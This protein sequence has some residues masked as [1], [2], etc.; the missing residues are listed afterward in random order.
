MSTVAAISTGMSPGGIGIVRISGENAVEI[1]EKVF[2]SKNGKLLKDLRG[3]SALLGSV[4]GED[5]SFLDEVIALVFKAPRSYTGEDVVELSCHGGLFVTRQVLRSVL[6]AGALPAPAGEFTKRAFLNGKMD[7]ASA[8]S[9]MNIISSHSE[10][11]AKAAYNTLEG[12]LSKKLAEINSVLVSA[13]ASL[14]AWVDYPD[15]EIE[16]LTSGELV[17]NLYSVKTDLE[18]LISRFDSGKAVIGG[19]RTA[20]V[21]KPN[22]GKSTLMNLLLGEDRSIVTSVEGTTRD[23]VEETAVIGSATLRLADTAGLRSSDDEV[24]KIG[25]DRAKKWLE[26]ADFVLAVFDAS[27]PITQEDE[28]IISLVK[29]K[30]SVAIFNKC[31]L[32][33]KATEDTIIQNFSQ[34]VEISAKNPDDRQKLCSVIEKT[35]ETADFDPSVASLINA[36]QRSCCESA[37]ND[38]KQAI[39]D[40]ENGVTLDAVNVTVDSAIDELLVLTGEKASDAVINE[41]FSRF[42]VGK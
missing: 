28:E 5:G 8:E 24:E 11:E 26:S 30:K 41:I 32:E 27:R 10:Q 13:S 3:Y 4:K 20:I 1:A 12:A 16:E 6:L 42:C 15:D 25:V 14:A 22:V 39:T 40:L 29:N 34:V 17:K 23:I 31:D 33:K 35:L 7:L 36:R 21:G 9:V 38:I 2:V 37:L 18:S 19:V